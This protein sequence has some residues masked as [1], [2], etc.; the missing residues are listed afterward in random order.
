MNGLM[1][2]LASLSERPPAIKYLVLS[3]KFTPLALYFFL[4]F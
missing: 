1:W 4:T 2:N 3:W